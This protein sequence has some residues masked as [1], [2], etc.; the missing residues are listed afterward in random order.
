VDSDVKKLFDMHAPKDAVAYGAHVRYTIDR[1]R[2]YG[3]PQYEAYIEDHNYKAFF[4]RLNTEI[5]RIAKL[6]RGKKIA[7]GIFLDM[8]L[9]CLAQLEPPCWN[10]FL[11]IR[12]RNPEV[13]VTH[14][15][16]VLKGN[17]RHMDDTYL[18]LAAACR[19]VGQRM[20]DTP[21]KI[22]ETG[23]GWA[24][25]DRN[26]WFHV[27]Y[28][29]TLDTLQRHAYFEIRAN[30]RLAVRKR[31][32]AELIHHVFEKTLETESIS[33]DPRIVSYLRY[34]APRVLG[35]CRL[36]CVPNEAAYSWNTMGYVHTDIYDEKLSTFPHSVDSF[37]DLELL[38]SSTE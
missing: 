30:V 24:E 22:P 36:P 28:V 17:S 31:L 16:T 23:W 37:R 27:L 13:V 11:R 29:P 3:N 32:P 35:K 20:K 8:M 9:D 5:L 15:K 12:T 4:Q 25:R 14:M 21:Y 19:R 6:P 2:S 33:S 7:L 10:P 18:D 38:E 26:D 1:A 34:P